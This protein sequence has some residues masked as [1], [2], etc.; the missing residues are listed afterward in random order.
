MNWE[1]F[2]HLSSLQTQIHWL[3]ALVCFGLGVIILLLKK[4]TAIHVLFG[5]AWV[6]LMVVVCL[7]AW[8]IR[9]F[10]PNEGMPL[11]YG[12]S[13]IHI[14]IPFTLILLLMGVRNIRR[15]KVNV[16]RN[17]MLFTFFGSLIIAGAFTFLPGRHMHSFFFGD[18]E[19]IERNID[20]GYKK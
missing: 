19:E 13:P 20:Q 6:G 7:S 12:F 5:R 10:S 14:L 2:I 15:K 1:V 17:I 3:L 18:K 16:H 9:G 11:L 4:G 8:F